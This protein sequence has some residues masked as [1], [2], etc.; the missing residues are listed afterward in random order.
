MSALNGIST[1]VQYQPDPQVPVHRHGKGSR[2]HQTTTKSATTTQADTDAGTSRT[3]G[4]GTAQT[5]YTTATRQMNQGATEAQAFQTAFGSGN[6]ANAQQASAAIYQEAQAPRG[7]DDEEPRTDSLDY[8]EEPEKTGEAGAS[9]S[10]PA[11]E[12]TSLLDVLA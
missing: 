4:Q 6:L 10:P 8:T 2:A 5:A 11:P 7:T 12:R 3:K 9:A 1:T